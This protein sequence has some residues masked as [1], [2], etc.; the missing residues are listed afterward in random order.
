MIDRCLNLKEDINRWL[1]IN[2][3]PE[4]RAVILTLLII[5]GFLIGL[6]IAGG[7]VAIWFGV[8]MWFTTNGDITSD[9]NQ[10]HGIGPLL[11]WIWWF[12]APLIPYTFY[13]IYRSQPEFKRKK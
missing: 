5:I 3:R 8:F 11:A 12:T 2:L 1:L 13:R 6:A 4:L 10:A 7:V 9:I